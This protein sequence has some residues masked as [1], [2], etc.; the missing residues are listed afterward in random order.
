[1]RTSDSI[2]NLAAALVKAQAMCLA[3]TKDKTAKVNSTKG[4]YE[5]N[6][7]D[8]A[9]V[10]QEIKPALAANDLAM[11]Q[12]SERQDDG[13]TVVTRLQHASGE[14]QETDT[15][16]PVAAVSAQAIGSAL[17]YG[18]RYGAQSAMLLP[19]ADDDGKAATDQP[20][21]HAATGGKDPARPNTGAQVAKD[22][23][24]DMP[25]DEQ[26]YLQD[27]AVAVIDMVDGGDDAHG[28]LEAQK[29]S[30]EQK[31]SLWSLLPSKVR[32]ALKKAQ[33]EA[34]MKAAASP[35]APKLVPAL[36]LASQP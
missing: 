14:W 3:V 20:P 30:L 13:I 21:A 4:S 22:A 29:L 11:I 15:F 27:L 33:A 2:A 6:Y 24:D 7:S 26:K 17:S 10:V 35:K 36:E 31:L 9:S 25:A 12:W 32:T 18:K 34:A 19:S 23:F 8:F 1:M 5:Y 28:Y 16:I